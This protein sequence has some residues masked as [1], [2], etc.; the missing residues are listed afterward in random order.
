[1]HTYSLIIISI[2]LNA[3]GQLFLKGGTEKVGVIH[4]D[5]VLSLLWDIVFN[6]MI[7]TGIICYTVS[8]GLWIMALSRVEVSFAYPMLS[9]GY[10]V[11]AIAAYFL[12][13]EPLSLMR[14]AGIAVIIVGVYMISR[15][16]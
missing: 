9:L 13:D 3:V 8:L 6:P 10:V 15:T 1:M 4:L 2:L 14:M 11:T 16:A 5:N 12:F 7:L